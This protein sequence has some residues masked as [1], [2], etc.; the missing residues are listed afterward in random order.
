MDLQELAQEVSI[1]KEYLPRGYAKLA[2][3][4]FNCSLTNVYKVAD[5][6]HQNTDILLYLVQLA[7]DEFE[8]RQMIKDKIAKFNKAI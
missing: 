1:I 2:A 4:E 8:K 3:V 6:K 7:E 5:G